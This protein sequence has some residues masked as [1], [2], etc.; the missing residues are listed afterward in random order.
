M[1][2]DILAG[3]LEL[4]QDLQEGDFLIF[5]NAGGYERSMSYGFGRG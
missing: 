1:E 3:S 4:P 2:D 5:G